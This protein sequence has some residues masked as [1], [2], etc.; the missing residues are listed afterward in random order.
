MYFVGVCV[1]RIAK[2]K[3]SSVNSKSVEGS[4]VNSKSAGGS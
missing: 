2:S 3:G 4:S 1:W